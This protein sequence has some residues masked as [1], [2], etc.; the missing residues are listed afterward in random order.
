MSDEQLLS[1]NGLGVHFHTYS[2][3][4]KAVDGVDLSIGKSELVGIVG[5]SGSGKSTL[6]Y[7]IMRLLPRKATISSGSKVLKGEDLTKLRE[8]E[9]KNVR[10][11]KISMVFQDPLSFLNPVM[12]IGDQIVE[13]ILTK[14]NL[15]KPQA[16]EEAVR[17]L[18]KV[19]IPRASRIM[20]EYP[21]QLSGGMRQRVLIAIAMSSDPLLLIAD[22]PTTALDVTVQA[23]ILGL[24]KEVSRTLG[25]SIMLI[26]HDLG[27]VAETC[28]RVYVMYAGKIFEYADVTTLF[29]NPLHPY[30]AALLDSAMSIEQFK[31]DLV[32]I[33][34]DVP[35]LISPPSGC[36]FHPRCTKAKPIC[37]REQPRLTLHSEKHGVYCWLY[38]GE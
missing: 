38:D 18:D 12:R 7:A 26:T 27:I 15:D 24:L 21:H 25:T 17:L 5:E 3:T 33:G 4:V 14:E 2:G 31:E 30:T 35:S 11:K 28:N 8:D 20:D 23:Q 13:S 19:R 32:G 29:E 37:T 1:I 16:R 36:R 22:E 6:A 34:G 10:G 9:V